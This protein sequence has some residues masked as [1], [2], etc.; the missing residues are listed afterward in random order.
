MKQVLLSL[1][2]F[3]LS[4]LASAQSDELVFPDFLEYDNLQ[5]FHI[6]PAGRGFAVGSCELLAR[7]SDG[8]QRWTALPKPIDRDLRYYVVDCEPG[9]NCQT[10]YLG[11]NRGTYRS[12]DAGESWRQVTN[13]WFQSVNF[14][15]AGT[16]LAHTGSNVMRSTDNGESWE[17]VDLPANITDEPIFVDANEWV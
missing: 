13:A 1:F 11:T 4:V 10:V 5:D 8:G 9:T 15:V 12:T 6:A 17:R 7:T 14:D 3:G 2:F 16:I